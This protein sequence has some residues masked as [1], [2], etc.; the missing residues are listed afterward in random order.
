MRTLV[1]LLS[2]IAVIGL[3]S[4]AY[5]ENYATQLALRDAARLQAEVRELREAIGVHRAEW[6]Y[7]N[8][9]DRLSDLVMKNFADLPLLP[10]TPAQFAAL[11]DLPLARTPPSEADAPDAA[12][13]R[14]AP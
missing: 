2:A 14:F 4:W 8:R 12:D 9:P 6:A 1:L 13:A 3:A 7:L 10:M 11:A 5:R